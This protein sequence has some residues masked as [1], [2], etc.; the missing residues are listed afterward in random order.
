MPGTHSS[1]ILL[2]VFIVDPEHETCAPGQCDWFASDTAVEESLSIFVVY[3]SLNCM[4]NCVIEHVPVLLVNVL[5]GI[6]TLLFIRKVC[7]ILFSVY[8]CARTLYKCLTDTRVSS[9]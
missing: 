1:K 2:A 7:F 8:T 6:T 5:G 9:R 3:C 4:E